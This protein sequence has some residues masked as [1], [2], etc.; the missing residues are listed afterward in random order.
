MKIHA[1]HIAYKWLIFSVTAV[2]V[3]M[4][5]LDGGIVNIALPVMAAD[6]NAGLERIQWVVSVYLLTTTCFL[7]VFG[8]L[9]DMYSRKYLYLTGF[10][11]FGIGSL[12]AAFSESLSWMIFSRIV[13]GL[14]ASAMISNCQAIIAKAFRGKDRGRALGGIGAMVAAGFLAGPA[15]GGFLIQHWGWQ[16]VFWINVPISAFGIWRGIQIIPLFKS[17]ERVKIDFMGAVCFILFC[18]CFLYALDEGEN[19]HWTSFLIMGSFGL[20]AL[21]FVIFYM[22]ERTSKNPFIGLS[23]FKIQAISYGCIV[24]LLGFIALNCNAILFPFYMSDILHLSPLQMSLLMMP[25]PIALAISSPFSGWLSERYSA[26]LITTV[27]FGFII[28]GACMFVGIGTHPSFIYIITAQLIM[29]MGSG[30]FQA[31]NN[32]T[33]IGGAP[34]DRLGMV[35]S[36]SALARNM[37][38]VMGIA[39]S[40]L[41]FSSVKRHYLASGIEYQAA[42]MHAYQAA[43]VFCII[44]ALAAAYFSAAREKRKKR[45]KQPKGFYETTTA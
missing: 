41:I 13:Q 3:F 34:Q 4:S 29:G 24:S 36:L 22:R 44:M 19:Q 37:G 40:V 14:G 25:F 32:N 16:S 2:G 21:F 12:L 11:L 6:L 23:L 30:T 43:M 42:F 39:L 27:G 31:P 35:V 8:K 7:P 10:L 17:H 15:V 45:K 20:S 33:I 28:L 38:A 1:P 5:T 18:F 26:R 9:S